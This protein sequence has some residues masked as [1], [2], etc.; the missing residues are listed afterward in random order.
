LLF[1]SPPPLKEMGRSRGAG[2][3]ASVLLT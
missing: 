1:H 3:K 2:K